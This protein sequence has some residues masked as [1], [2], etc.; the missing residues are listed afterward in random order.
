MN[1]NVNDL[2]NTI[3]LVKEKLT[4]DEYKKLIE[5]LGK[6]HNHTSPLCK[7]VVLEPCVSQYSVLVV[8]AE[9]KDDIYVK[10]KDD[11]GV[12]LGLEKITYLCSSDIKD[13]FGVGSTIGKKQLKKYNHPY[14]ELSI[15]DRC[16]DRCVE[17]LHSHE[18][19]PSQYT[20]DITD[21]G[22]YILSID[23]L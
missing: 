22:C 2:L 17:V 8:T 13:K 5:S 3:E 10:E 7:V 18:E 12:V 11:C 15:G 19:E 14:G 6:L 4:D 9:S 23:N 20:I 21:Y 1:N 16:Y